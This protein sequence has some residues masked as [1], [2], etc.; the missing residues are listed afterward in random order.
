MTVS[1]PVDPSS[2]KKPSAIRSTLSSNSYGPTPIARQIAIRTLQRRAAERRSRK[3]LQVAVAIRSMPR[4]PPATNQP[5]RELRSKGRAQPGRDP[6]R[7]TPPLAA[8]SQSPF[9]ICVATSAQKAKRLFDRARFALRCSL[10]AISRAPTS[11]CRAHSRAAAAGGLM[12]CET[13]PFPACFEPPPPLTVMARF[14]HR[15]GRAF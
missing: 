11:P 14:P 6:D 10:R 1:A 5:S 12:K 13:S 15:P 3:R 7:T 2:A 4:V 8:G 9:A